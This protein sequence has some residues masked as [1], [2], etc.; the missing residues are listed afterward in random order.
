MTEKEFLKT[1]QYRKRLNRLEEQAFEKGDFLAALRYIQRER[2][3]FGKDVDTNVHLADVYE[4]MGLHALSIKCWYK[5]LD[6]CAV[7]DFA[8]VYEGLAGNYLALSDE[9]H[10]AYYYDR[11]MDADAMISKEYKEDIIEAF[12]KPKKSLFRVVYPPEQADY[13]KEMEEGAAR[14]KKGDCRRA[15]EALSVVPF[16]TK[17]YSSAREMQAVAYLL[18]G[19]IEEAEKISLEL[20]ELYPEK[21]QPYTTLAAVYLE[22]GKAEECRKIAEKLCSFELKNTEEKFKVATV[23]CEAGLHE[24]AHELLCEVEK[25]M[26][27]DVKTL[28]FQAVSAYKCGKIEKSIRALEKLCAIYENAAVAKYY[29]EE[30]K[31]SVRWKDANG[32]GFSF[33]EI[34]ENAPA[35]FEV[36]ITYYYRLPEAE[37]ERRLAEFLQV[38]AMPKSEAKKAGKELEKRG[39]LRWC[40][41][42]LDGMDYDLQ[43][44]AIMVAEHAEC[45]NFLREILLDN[46][47]KEVLKIEIIN[48]LCMRNRDNEFGVVLYDVYREIQTYKIEI[49]RKKRKKFLSAYASVF[50]R[51]ALLKEGLGDAIATAAEDL[52]LNVSLVGE[53][54]LFDD[55]KSTACAIYFCAKVGALK[56]PVEK[57]V[58][59]FEGNEECVA[60]LLSIYRRFMGEEDETN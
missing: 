37:R 35:L 42:E 17:E 57:V 5:V 45:D 54:D 16:G 6:N 56:L 29:L 31:K 13:S 48:G 41:D 10:A 39:A 32:E 8:D 12:S 43:Y 21:P 27:Y 58:Q 60:K 28:Y 18:E 20:V 3:I 26:P 40:F 51:F 59:V 25:D 19:K 47:V 46:E 30:I 34:E 15:I 52:Y 55:E 50:S 7:E 23:A 49:G 9:E 14:L 22:Q 11:L 2:E 33:L 1:E 36:D 24:Q 44:L 53:E 4:A 38:S